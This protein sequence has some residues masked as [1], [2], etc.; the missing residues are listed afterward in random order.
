V[1]TYPNVEVPYYDVPGGNA[2]ISMLTADRSTFAEKMPDPSTNFIGEAAFDLWLN[3]WNIEVMVWTDN[4]HQVPFGNK[5]ATAN[6]FGQNFN[7]WQSGSD[8]FAFVPDHNEQTGT[9]HILSTL[10]WLIRNGKIPASSTLTSAQFGGKCAPPPDRRCS[11]CPS[12]RTPRFR[13]GTTRPDS[14]AGRGCRRVMDRRTTE[15]WRR[16]SD[17]SRQRR[18]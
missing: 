8:A 14:N 18:S 1:E 5:V 4:H 6:V 3:K 9:V 7:V 10:R 2:P 17:R 12:T 13:R 11:T 16:Q 15:S